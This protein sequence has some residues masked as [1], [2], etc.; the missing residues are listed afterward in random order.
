MTEPNA[1]SPR[2]FL[3]GRRP[4]RFSDSVAVSD[5]QLD[6]TLLEYQ[7]DTLTSR[8]QE[9]AFQT[10]GRHLAEKEI[11]PNLLPQTGPTGGG[12]SKV[13]S[14]TYPV[15]DDLSLGWYTGIGRESASERWA[16]AISAKADWRTKVRADVKKIAETKRGYSKAFFVSNQF[17]RDR[18]RADIEDELSKLHGMDVRIHD[19]TW[20]LD[21]VFGGHH[22]TIA[23]EDLQMQPSLRTQIRTGPRDLERRQ[24]LDELEARIQATTQS[25]QFG[26][27]FVD[28]CIQAADLSRCL[29][30][31]R[32]ETDGRF[33]RADRAASQFGTAHQQLRC[34]YEYAWTAIFWHEDLLLAAQ[35]Y[36]SVESKAKGT[37]NAYELE[38]L[39]NLWKVLF[40]LVR[41]G[42]LDAATASLDARTSLLI[43]ELDRLSAEQERPSNALQA[44]SIRAVMQLLQPEPNQIDDRLEELR[45]VILQSRGL[46]GFPL[47]SLVEALTEVGGSL[48]TY[49]GYDALHDTI[50]EVVTE[51]EGDIA[52]A[53]LLLQ[54]G[55]NNLTRIVQSRPYVSWARH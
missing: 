52:A 45:A 8:S 2:D 12:D 9:T 53:R 29:E 13:D 1:F 36:G 10:F 34:A 23:I 35:L 26:F 15:A 4:E 14:E 6:R 47:E 11:C 5:P 39:S 48:G 18:D 43:G 40:A 24:T 33:I 28:D 41:I 27:Q 17:V 55:R 32:S 25:G 16:F 37:H 38:L 54:R 3:K 49:A 44:R 46:V 19:R 20:I 30:Q 7:L 51:R 50:I 22:E 21:K 31:P 42:K